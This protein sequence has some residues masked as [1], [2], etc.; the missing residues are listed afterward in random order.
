MAAFVA[1]LMNGGMVA[2]VMILR[3]G[4]RIV[5]SGRWIVGINEAE[6]FGEMEEEDSK[7]RLGVS[8]WRRA[9]RPLAPAPGL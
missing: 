3:V 9:L 6:E 1:R 2:V 4:K 8:E 5:R 7:T